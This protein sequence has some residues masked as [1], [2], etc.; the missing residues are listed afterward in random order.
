MKK[1]GECPKHK[2]S[3]KLHEAVET[4]SKNDEN[5]KIDEQAEKESFAVKMNLL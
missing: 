5:K 4:E 2:N 3:K 1:E